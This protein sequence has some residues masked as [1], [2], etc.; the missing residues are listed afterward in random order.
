MSEFKEDCE[1]CELP[2]YLCSCQ[3]EDEH[4]LKKLIDKNNILDMEE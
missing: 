4:N 2:L 3:D 1:W